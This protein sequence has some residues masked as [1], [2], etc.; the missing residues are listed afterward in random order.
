[1]ED[2]E[3]QLEHYLQGHYDPE[4]ASKVRREIRLGT[5]SCEGF[6]RL[7]RIFHENFEALDEHMVTGEIEAPQLNGNRDL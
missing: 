4:V 1:M 5:V 6:M 2:P 7:D 3:H